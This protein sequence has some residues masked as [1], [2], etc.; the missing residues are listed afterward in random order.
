MAVLYFF[1]VIPTLKRLRGWKPVLEAALNV[2]FT[3]HIKE[4]GRI[5]REQH[6]QTMLVVFYSINAGIVF[7]VVSLL[8]VL[9]QTV[10]LAM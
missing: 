6:N 9:A 1:K 3:R 2:K 4:Y 5:A 7:S 10:I 8:I